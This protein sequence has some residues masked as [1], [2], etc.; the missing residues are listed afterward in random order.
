VTTH[1]IRCSVQINNWNL[2]W[3]CT[4][5]SYMCQWQNVTQVRL[6]E[7]EYSAVSTGG[8]C[9]IVTFGTPRAQHYCYMCW[10]CHRTRSST[11]QGTFLG[12]IPQI[13][14]AANDVFAA[15]CQWCSYRYVE[16]VH[17]NN[18]HSFYNPL[19]IFMHHY[20]QVTQSVHS[21]FQGF[22]PFT[23]FIYGGIQS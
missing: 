15:A 6:P 14:Y 1:C 8:N 17:Q 7:W 12:K 13:V 19:D 3:I 2:L 23:H 5:I 9:I 10:H 4:C 16:Q 20:S 11:L 18:S 21:H 22:S